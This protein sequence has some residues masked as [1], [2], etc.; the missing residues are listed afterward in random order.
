MRRKLSGALRN[1]FRSDRPVGV[2]VVGPAVDLEPV[3]AIQHAVVDE[4]GGKDVAVLLEL[5]VAVET[6]DEHPE[7]VALSQGRREVD[8]PGKH[9]GEAESKEQVLLAAAHGGDQVVLDGAL[10]AEQ[11]SLV[12]EIEFLG[13]VTRL[14]AGDAHE[15]VIVYPVHEGAQALFRVDVNLV[16]LA[17]PD[18]PDAVNARKRF[19]HVE[20]LPGIEPV[21][22]EDLVERLTLL[23]DAADPEADSPPRFASIDR[24]GLIRGS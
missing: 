20:E 10:E 14:G 21:A 1:A 4:F 9:I 15:R 8:V 7:R 11:L 18:L 17:R 12:L 5:A 3:C 24:L 23:D 22:L 2:V 13:L 19:L 6:L 16:G